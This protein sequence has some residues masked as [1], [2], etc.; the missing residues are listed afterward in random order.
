MYNIVQIEDMENKIYDRVEKFSDISSFKNIHCAIDYNRI[1]IN[2]K[3]KVIN[4]NLF[5]F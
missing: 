3:R 1:Q 2:P 4:N 5:R